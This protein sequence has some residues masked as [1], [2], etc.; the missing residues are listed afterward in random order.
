[1]RSYC[2]SLTTKDTGF[3]GVGMSTEH[4][5]TLKMKGWLMAV[6][7]GLVECVI[8]NNGRDLGL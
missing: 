4:T 3:R 5:F 1:M 6:D 2:D 8:R 7:H